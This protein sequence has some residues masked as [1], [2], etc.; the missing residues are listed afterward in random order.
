MPACQFCSPLKAK[1][2][3]PNR[4][5]PSTSCAWC[6]CRRASSTPRNPCCSQEDVAMKNPDHLSAHGKPFDL[7]LDDLLYPA[8]AF[9]HPKEVLIDPDL[10]VNEKRA[11]LASWASDA[12]AV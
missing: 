6:R 10:T 2:L 3:K 4:P 7:D 8:Q 11:I 9:A 1:P 12:C 5:A